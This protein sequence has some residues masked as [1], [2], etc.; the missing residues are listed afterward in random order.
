[1]HD[2]VYPSIFL[3]YL[4]FFLC[5]AG[6]LFFLLRSRKDGY[7]GKNSEDPKY[8]MLTNDDAVVKTESNE[9]SGD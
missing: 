6:A 7:W 1:M 5:F 2:Y 9:D 8:R 3:A 4:M